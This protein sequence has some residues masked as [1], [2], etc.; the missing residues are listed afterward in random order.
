MEIFSTA[1]AYSWLFL[2][3]RNL[4]IFAITE[5]VYIS[6]K[7]INKW[8]IPCAVVKSAILPFVGEVF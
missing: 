4:V 8:S 5:F 6:I 2:Y 3:F 1:P 7:P